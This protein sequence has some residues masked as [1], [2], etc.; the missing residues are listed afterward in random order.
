[1]S[2]QNTEAGYHTQRELAQAVGLSDAWLSRL[3]SR[4][5][6]P[7][8]SHVMPGKKRPLYS[9]EEFG[10]LRKMKIDR[11]SER[12]AN[13]FVTLPKGFVPPKPKPVLGKSRNPDDWDM[14]N[15]PFGWIF[16][17][18]GTDL[19]RE[20]SGPGCYVKQPRQVAVPYIKSKRPWLDED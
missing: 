3:I 16:A 19:H 15:A 10:Q 12:T 20:A 13:T 6:I 4:G 1:M 14:F 17:E 8:P 9:D 5:E 7:P 2:K 18:R 11:G